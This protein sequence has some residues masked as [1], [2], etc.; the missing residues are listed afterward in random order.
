MSNPLSNMCYFSTLFITEITPED[1][2]SDQLAGPE[3]TDEI[4]ILHVCN[5][6]IFISYFLY[7]KTFHENNF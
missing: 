7:K 5:I 4:Y 3:S 6:G 1:Q 2:I